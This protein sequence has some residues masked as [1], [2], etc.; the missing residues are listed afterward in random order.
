MTVT[1]MPAALDDLRAAYAFY[2]AR[3]PDAAGRVV[4]AILSAANG[5][6]AFPFL[7]RPGAVPGTRER[8]VT[9]FP[10]RIVYQVVDERIEVLRVLRTAQRWP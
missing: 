1:I 5:L 2:A 8:L 9:H 3:S 7:G 10:Y 4:G 6:A